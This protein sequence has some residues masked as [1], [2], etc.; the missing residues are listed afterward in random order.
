[1]VTNRRLI[2]ES[3]TMA[4]EKVLMLTHTTFGPQTPIL[5]D[6]L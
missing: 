4:H 6:L 5:M 1:M 3:R 2:M